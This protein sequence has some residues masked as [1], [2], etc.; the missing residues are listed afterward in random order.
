MKR[1]YSFENRLSAVKRI[2]LEDES[3]SSVARSIG[4][5]FTPVKRWLNRYELHGEEGLKESKGIYTREFKLDVIKYMLKNGLPL[6][7]A[8][9]HFGIP[10]ETTVSKWLK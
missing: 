6:M 10:S 8:A 5:G 7:R 2:L 4:A 1:K 3:I 9:A